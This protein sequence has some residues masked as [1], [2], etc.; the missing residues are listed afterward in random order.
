MLEIYS[1]ISNP[2]L[3]AFC[4]FF[5]GSQQEKS[6][7]NFLRKISNKSRE[8][9]GKEALQSE[10]FPTSY[11][12]IYSVVRGNKRAKNKIK[13]FQILIQKSLYH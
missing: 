12:I 1:F 11:L 9:K 4:I 7:K 8:S 5:E 10:K 6:K 2:N 13:S 3:L